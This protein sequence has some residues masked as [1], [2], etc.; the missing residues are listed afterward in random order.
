[1]AVFIRNGWQLSAGIGGRFKTEWV[2]GLVRNI[3]KLL[4]IENEP[5][6]TKKAA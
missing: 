1:V 6:K 3:H 2:A 5:V 4:E